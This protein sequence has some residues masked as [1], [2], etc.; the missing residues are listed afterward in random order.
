[1]FSS[2]VSTAE[3]VTEISGRGVG[4]TATKKACEEL[5]GRVEV[6]SWKGV[7]TEITFVLPVPSGTK[8]VSDEAPV[9]AELERAS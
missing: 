4:T 7:G 3:R 2:G 9:T 8:V 1:M 6:Q 5:G